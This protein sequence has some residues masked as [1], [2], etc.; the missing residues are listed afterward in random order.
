MTLSIEYPN[1]V[2]PWREMWRVV[3]YALRSL[4]GRYASQDAVVDRNLLRNDALIFFLTCHHLGDH[5]WSDPAANLTKEQVGNYIGSSDGLSLVRDFSN[6]FKHHTRE[7][8]NQRLVRIRR[9]D[10]NPRALWMGWTDSAGK[11]HQRDVLDV[12]RSAVPDWEAFLR[13]SGLQ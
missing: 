13:S 3:G 10:S 8:A 12:A 2:R 5:L 9:Y 4:E 1:D 11:T 6:S 7:H